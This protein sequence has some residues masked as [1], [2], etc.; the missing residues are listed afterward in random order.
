[1]RAAAASFVLWSLLPG[2]AGFSVR[3]ADLRRL[4]AGELDPSTIVFT[5]H[6]MLFD[7]GFP[8]DY[9]LRDDLAA[10]PE[11][12]LA[13]VITY[14][15]EPTGV[16]FN[17]GSRAPGKLLAELAE[18]LEELHRA[19]GCRGELRLAAV[20][21]SAGCEAILDAAARLKKARLQ[22]VL[23]L[24]SSSFAFSTEPA[25]LVAEG[26]IG[27]LFS[28]WSPLDLVT[29]F[30]PLGAGGLGLHP[31][32]PG[33]ENLM[34]LNTH[35]PPLFEAGRRRAEEILLGAGSGEASPPHTCLNDAGY[36]RRLAEL[37]RQRR[38]RD[39]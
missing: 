7:L 16:W 23:F 25:R 17:W 22:R 36:R 35:L 2:C 31:E 1:V 6:G 5:C 11:G 14:P 29:F 8:W 24:N 12:R 37:L 28:T 10:G 15:T 26:R 27:R 4:E 34:L 33:L 39:R 20:G 30:A 3:E 19:S 13:L 38:S 9:R 18:E 21:F 32:I